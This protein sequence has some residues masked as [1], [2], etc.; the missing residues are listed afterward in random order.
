[1]INLKL[2]SSLEKAFLD[3]SIDGFEPIEYISTLRGERVSLQLL[4]SY[5]PKAGE[6]ELPAVI[7]DIKPK[8][9]LAR[10]VRVRNVRHL[11]VTKPCHRG[12][13]VK[14]A[15]YLK[16]TPGVYPD[17]LTPLT[18]LGRFRIMRGAL[19]SLWIDIEIPE[20]APAGECTLTVTTEAEPEYIKTGKRII[21]EDTVTIEVIDATLPEQTLRFTQWFHNGKQSELHSSKRNE[22]KKSRHTS[23]ILRVCSFCL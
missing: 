23:F 18:N 13:H 6:P 15:G 22:Q 4:V 8:G 19:D 20:D 17:L 14:T 11:G 3:Q 21:G 9:A 12:T 5:E 16:N 7:L 2:V 10:H 1:M